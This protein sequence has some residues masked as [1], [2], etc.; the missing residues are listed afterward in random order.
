MIDAYDVNDIEEMKISDKARNKSR[1]QELID[2]A[3]LSGFRKIGVA[4]CKAVQSYADKLVEILK[5]A[6]FEVF[7]MSCKES[8]LQACEISPELKGPSCDP[9]SQAEYL[10]A[11]GTDLNIDVGLCLGHGLIFQ[12]HSKAMVTTF[13]VKDFATQHKTVENLL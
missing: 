6:G 10:N 8:G 7:A 12:K 4:N 13:L 1:L 9:V 2:F 11:Q 5:N 3:K